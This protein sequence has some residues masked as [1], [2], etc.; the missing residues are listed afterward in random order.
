MKG[1]EVGGAVFQEGK[2]F[3]PFGMQH[4][5]SFATGCWLTRKTHHFLGSGYPAKDYRGHPKMYDQSVIIFEE[6]PWSSK[7]GVNKQWPF[8]KISNNFFRCNKMALENGP[9]DPFKRWHLVTCDGRNRVYVANFRVKQL[10][11]LPIGQMRLVYL[12]TC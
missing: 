12:P 2:K 11:Q 5:S 8:L 9:E 1:L 4:L 3:W 10:K 6:N 7:F